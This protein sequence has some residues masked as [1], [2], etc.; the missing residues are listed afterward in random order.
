M[1]ASNVLAT[2]AFNLMYAQKLVADLKPEQ[3]CAQPGGVPN[4][5]VWVIGHLAASCDFA[6]SFLN[7]APKSPKDW[8]ELFGNKSKPTTDASKYPP[9]TTLIAAL[10]DGHKRVGDALAVAPESLLAGPCKVEGINKRF[11]TIGEVMTFMLSSHEA[12]HLGQL[13]AWRR[14]SGLPSVF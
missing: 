6:G 7:V 3:A 4:H 13:S 2:Y 10:E 9:L 1:P 8:G 11:P 12:M 14:A 5:A